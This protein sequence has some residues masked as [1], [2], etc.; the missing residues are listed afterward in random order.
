MTN[1]YLLS[2]LR[3]GQDA[4]SDIS[5]EGV[6]CVTIMPLQALQQITEPN[7]MCVSYWIKPSPFL[8]IFV[9]SEKKLGLKMNFFCKDIFQNLEMKHAASKKFYFF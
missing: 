3:S 8:H 9:V 4:K 2:R 1:N 5:S 6:K 7:E